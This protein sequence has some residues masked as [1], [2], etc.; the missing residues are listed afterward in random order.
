[1][2]EQ[3]EDMSILSS[4][5]KGGLGK[6]LIIWFLGIALLPLF[7]VSIITYQSAYKSLRSDAEIQLAAVARDKKDQLNSFFGERTG[8]IAVLSS[9]NFTVQTLQSL[10]HATETTGL[11][12][13][14]FVES[15]VWQSIVKQYGKEYVDFQEAYGYYD[16]FLI[17]NKGNILYSVKGEDDDLGLSV[18]AGDYKDTKLS[19]ACRKALDTNEPVFSDFEEYEKS[20]NKTSA[21]IVKGVRDE[22]GKKIGILALQVGIRQI[23]SIL[24]GQSGLGQRGEIDLVSTSDWEVKSSSVEDYDGSSAGKQIEEEESKW[25]K[26]NSSELTTGGEG[27]I[28]VFSRR[29]GK[30]ELGI[31]YDLDVIGVKMAIIAT[32]DESKALHAATQQQKIA[33]VM[34]L[35]TTIFVVFAALIVTRRIVR[36]ILQLSRNARR[37]AIGDLDY[38]EI[39]SSIYEIVQMSTD[40]KDLMNSRRSITSVCEDVAGGDLRRTVSVRSEEDILCTAINQIIENLRNVV[41]QADAIAKGDYSI[42]VTPLSDNDEIGMSL[43][44]MTATLREATAENEKQTWLKTGL[45]QLYDRIRGEQD[46]IGLVQNII[47]FLT[48]Y[49]DTQV[50]AFFLVDEK[51]MLKLVGSYAYTKRKNISNEYTVGEGLVGQA[52]LEKK[53]ILITR[54]PDDYVKINSGLGEAVPRNLLVVPSVYEGVVKGVIELG[55]FHEFAD[56]KI[57]FL[58]QAATSIAIAINT[59]SSR[60]RMRGLLD[61]T[62]RQSEELQVQQ[63]ELRQTNEELEEQTRALRDSEAKLQVQQ[64]ELRQTNEELEE[65]NRYLEKQQDDIRKKN[66]ELEYNRHLIEEKA[67]D[68]ELSGKYKSEF[69]ANMSHELRTPLNSLLILSRLLYENKESNLTEK[70]VE[71]A[72]TIY[73]AGSDLLALINDILD[74]SKVEA[75]KVELDIHDVDIIDFANGIERN[76]RHMAE[77]KG[78]SFNVELSGGIPSYIRTDRQRVEQI[79]KNLLSNAIKFTSKGSILLKISRPEQGTELLR[80]GL[81]LENSIAF[82]VIDTGIGIAADKQKL[83]FEA[84]Q[85]ADGTTS[86]QYGGTG[87]GL[88][89]SRELAKYLGGEIQLRSQEGV[90][91]TFTIYL[92]ELSQMEQGEKVPSRVQRDLIAK[93]GFQRDLTEPKELEE[94]KTQQI[95]AQKPEQHTTVKT[96]Q[97]QRREV[98]PSDRSVLIIEDDSRFS[99]I[100]VEL[101][102]GKGFKVFAAEDGETGLQYA[103][104][105]KPSAII[106]DV[107]LPG[108]D[109][110]TV[111]EKLKDNPETRHIPVHFISAYDSGLDAMKMGAIGYLT[112]PVSMEVLDGAFNKIENIVSKNVK[113]LLVVEDDEL[114]QRSILELIGDGDVITTAVGSGREAFQLLKTDNFDCVVLDLGLQDMSGFDLLE[115]IRRDKIISHIPVII[116]TGKDLTKEEDARLREHAESIII[117]GVKSPERL[118]DETTL[119]LHRVEANLSEERQKMLKMIHNKEMIFHDKKV[120]LVDD[121]MRNVFA[122][123]NV[124]EEKGMK[125]LVG[126]NGKEGLSLLNDN[127]DADLVLM[128]IMMPEMDG[129]E[130]M[131]EIRKQDKFRNIPIIALTAKAMV[132][133]RNKCIEAGA[134]DYLSKPIDTDKLLSL[135]RV[136]LYR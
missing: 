129:Y 127:P 15:P 19:Q 104:K 64:E 68:L 79:V 69:L 93:K 107:G 32:M 125:V 39:S 90:G 62:Q 50:G 48:D 43:S 26:K 128:D 23:D 7:L 44:H 99:T 54:V 17:D 131:R 28:V 106:L 60:V 11:K 13:G 56:V 8:D 76:F 10:I 113:K 108:I 1:M 92:P 53:N 80:S 74:L 88:S 65:K 77:E 115:K 2:R 55:S 109:G 117:K 35:V 91:S 97:D 120:L 24:H 102:K 38:E 83:I 4:I 73:S 123:L 85:Q 89:I 101:A 14:E 87:L 42:D 94:Q 118:L 6:T 86:R 132:G 57:D 31:R 84:F 70:Q 122:L 136:W 135:L 22:T 9:R 134:S 52:A 100:L 71:F 75:G 110:W 98:L 126:K 96:A 133:D 33:I 81:D 121:D 46:L 72:R 37:V 16:L 30:Q 116:Y 95:V 25:Y 112:K 119:F 41:Q 59:A 124:L 63:E 111:M 67:K 40:F 27:K 105:Y 47:S 5:K 51:N 82:M 12:P 103:V 66:E 78:L 45:N 20:N 49:L 61:E 58:N 21:F 130:A 18:F 36:P 3:K 34:A 114:Q 29:E